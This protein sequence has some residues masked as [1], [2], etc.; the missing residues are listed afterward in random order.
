MNREHVN[1]NCVNRRNKK[2]TV[3]YKCIN[4]QKIFDCETEL[5]K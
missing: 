4:R 3:N 1:H 2:L 5:Y